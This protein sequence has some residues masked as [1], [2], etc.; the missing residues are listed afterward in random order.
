MISEILK[1]M[2]LY[3]NGNL[4]DINHFIKV[5]AY[6]KTIAELEG[7]DEST[8]Y[9]LETAAIVHDIA[10]P[11]LRARSGSCDGK[12]QEIEGPDLA[13]EFLKEFEFSEEQL[14]RVLYLV[15]HHH[16]CEDV[17]GIDYQILL[18]A[19]YIV[20]ADESGYSLESIKKTDAALFRTAS[21]KSILESIFGF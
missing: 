10:C 19:D 11:V 6:A 2:I 13:K 5:W 20:N 4:H 9:I 14:N 8:K 21:G 1:K 17:N 18:E 16:T 15:G 3:S 12:M 7:V